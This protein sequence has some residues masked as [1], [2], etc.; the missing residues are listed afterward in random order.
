MKHDIVTCHLC[1]SVWQTAKGAGPGDYQR[2]Y[3]EAHY[4][5]E[6]ERCTR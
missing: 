6:A 4:D 5:L 1:G 2:H 3:V